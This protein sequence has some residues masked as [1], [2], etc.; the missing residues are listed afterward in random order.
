VEAALDA[1]DKRCLALVD[2]PFELERRVRYNGGLRMSLANVLLHA[3]EV[4]QQR[5]QVRG[6]RLAG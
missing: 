2:R 4:T 6:L 1:V 5:R 3:L